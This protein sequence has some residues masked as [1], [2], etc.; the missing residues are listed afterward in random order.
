M[1]RRR[2]IAEAVLVSAAVSGLP[3]TLHALAARRSLRAAGAAAL[4]ATRAVGTLIPPGRP[5]VVRGAVVHLAISA[6]CGEG[7]ARTLPRHHTVAWGAGAGLLIGI[8]NVG[9]I[10]RAFPAIRALPFA[11][12]LADNVAFGVLFALVVDRP[13][14]GARA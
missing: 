2:R 11:P 14:D 10:G 9:V 5:G 6:A 13:R 3:S 1:R 4:E 7:L 8:V 12:A